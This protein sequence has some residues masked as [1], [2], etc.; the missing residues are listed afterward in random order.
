MGNETCE[1]I[2]LTGAEIL[3]QYG[4]PQQTDPPLLVEKPQNRSYVKISL[5]AI[6]VSHRYLEA[7]MEAKE[8]F[9]WFDYKALQ[10]YR[11]DS[12]GERIP[13]IFHYH[14]PVTGGVSCAHTA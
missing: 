7:R 8:R 11:S 1:S 4:R 12:L 13:Y 5:S 14:R 2:I 9:D 10:V 3:S 6:N